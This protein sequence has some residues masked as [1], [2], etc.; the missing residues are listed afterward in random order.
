[1]IQT[2]TKQDATIV[3]LTDHLVSVKHPAEEECLMRAERTATVSQE[4]LLH[5][6]AG[7]SGLIEEALTASLTAK[8]HNGVN[9][10]DNRLEGMLQGLAERTL[11]DT[12]RSIKFE[13]SL[14]RNIKKETPSGRN[15]PKMTIAI[16][17]NQDFIASV[18]TIV[19]KEMRSDVDIDS[20]RNKPR[21]NDFEAVYSTE[22]LCA[23]SSDQPRMDISYEQANKKVYC[24]K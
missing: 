9:K 1:M 22:E 4:T 12:S 15:V 16:L 3:D 14:L 8:G 24:E 7:I 2:F 21:R 13:G 10:T 17:D 11:G 6:T 20:E 5:D 18:V 23:T 19:T